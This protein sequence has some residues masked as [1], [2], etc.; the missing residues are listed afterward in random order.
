MRISDWSS[1]VCSSDL[2]EAS[3]SAGKMMV[4]AVRLDTFEAE[5]QSTT[6]YIGCNDPA[7]LGKL[8]RLILTDCASLPIAGEYIHRDAFDLADR[9]GKDQ[10]VTIERLGT[11]RLPRSHRRPDR[12]RTLLNSSH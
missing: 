4:F 5:P 8:R 12:K 2:F 3:G 9:Y 6:F 1:D 10:F 7:E 11:A